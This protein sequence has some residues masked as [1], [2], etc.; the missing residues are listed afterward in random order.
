MEFAVG[1]M[2]AVYTKDNRTF[3]VTEYEWDQVGV[4][5]DHRDER[6]VIP[7]TNISRIVGNLGDQT[8]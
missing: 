2:V 6:L 4:M 5:L 3:H 8:T 1:A 7:W